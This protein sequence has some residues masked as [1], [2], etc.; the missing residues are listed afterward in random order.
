MNIKFVL[1]GYFYPTQTGGNLSLTSLAS[2]LFMD[3]LTVV[4]YIRLHQD[5]TVWCNASVDGTIHCFTFMEWYFY[6]N[7]FNKFWFCKKNYMSWSNRLMLIINDIAACF[8]MFLIVL[9]HYYDCCAELP[10]TLR[11][12]N[13]RY[14]FAI[15]NLPRIRSQHV[16]NI[17]KFKNNTFDYTPKFTTLFSSFWF[18]FA[19]DWATTN[20]IL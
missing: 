6:K 7:I 19:V 2:F 13:R 10:P 15:G 4:Y 12:R 8:V 3:V 1:L 18:K 11:E 5:W 17:G 9:V 14:S 16:D 20:H